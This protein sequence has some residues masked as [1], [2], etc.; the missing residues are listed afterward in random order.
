MT[1]HSRIKKIQKLMRKREYTVKHKTKIQNYVKKCVICQKNKDGKQK[2]L[3]TKQ[4][5][6]ASEGS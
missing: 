2:R 3:K 5:L 6:S 1:T 4:T